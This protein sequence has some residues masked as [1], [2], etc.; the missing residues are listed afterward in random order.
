M[1]QRMSL[2]HFPVLPFSA[3]MTG[4]AFSYKACDRDQLF[5]L[6]PS[7]ADWLEDGHLAWFVID[8]VSVVETSGFH[9]AHP[10]DGAGQ[11]AYDPEMMLALLLYAYCSGLRSSRRIEAA[12]SSDLA[13]RVIC[14]NMVPDHNTIA[15]FRAEHED[16][17]AEVFFEVLRLCA[18]AGMASLGRIA[19]DGTKIG[20]DAALDA[21][22]SAEAIRA[23]VEAMLGQAADADADEESL[24]GEVRPG[25]LPEA[26]A[27]P[28]HS[29]LARLR[30]ALAEVE[31]AEAVAAEEA[32]RRDAKAIA[33]AAEGRKL[34]GRRPTDLHAALTRAEADLAVERAKAEAKADERARRA[35]N[36]EAEGRK[37]RG[38][39]PGP[40]VKLDK[41]QARLDEA[42]RV[43]AGTPAPRPVQANTTDPHSRIMKSVLG[44]IQGYNAQAAVNEGQLVMAAEV[45]QEGNDVRQLVP[46]MAATRFALDA[47]G[48]VGEVECL[49][50]DAGYWS[51]ANAGAPG[52]DRLIAT[53]KD[54]KQR[55]KAREMGTTTGPPPDGATALAAMEHRLR[56]PE[57]TKA[58]AQRSTTV[59]P[60][61]GHIKENR[62]YRRFM[63]RGLPAVQ[64]EWRLICASANLLKLFRHL[65]PGGLHT[66]ASPVTA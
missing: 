31:A 51:E 45:T 58:Y 29:R 52:P 43:A 64:S 63:R 56:T 36:A 30:A 50:A 3:I 12:C 42:R 5:L 60:V 66:P 59:E 24:F 62:G 16:A 33:E 22:R 46:M 49:L 21:N 15:R 57:G 54:W 18:Q 1:R 34:M 41:A 61:F 38:R 13:Y 47:A 6:P 14:A 26:L 35:Q 17:I 7:M 25:A 40:D 2:N 39:P 19:I 44:W 20:A 9:A 48:I 55:R 27:R 28:G 11:P 53:T 10:N 65:P 8:V 23:E 4:M 32:A 37:L